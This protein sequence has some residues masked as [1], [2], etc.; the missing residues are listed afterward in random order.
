MAGKNIETRSFSRLYTKNENIHFY[1]ILLN[2]SSISLF[3]YSHISYVIK[4]SL[5]I[6]IFNKTTQNHQL[7]HSQEYSPFHSPLTKIIVKLSHHHFHFCIFF[8]FSFN[9]H[10]IF[11]FS[12]QESMEQQDLKKS[13]LSELKGTGWIII[14]PIYLASDITIE[15]GRRVSKE[16]GGMMP[17]S[18]SHRFY[19]SFLFSSSRFVARCHG[20]LKR[21]QVRICY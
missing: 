2:N 18:R 16:I 9:S 5:R 1:F 6:Q 21:P 10:L 20:S 11:S 7:F 12:S 15:R 13:F 19:L 3:Y 8:C 17:Y 14:Y 4:I